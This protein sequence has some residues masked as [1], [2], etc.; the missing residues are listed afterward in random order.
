[1]ARK[2]L[3]AANCACLGVSS[4]KSPKHHEQTLGRIVRGIRVADEFAARPSAI[5]PWQSM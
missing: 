2:F 3:N 1:M 4:S 5:S